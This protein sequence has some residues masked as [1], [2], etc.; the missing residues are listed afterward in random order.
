LRA[1]PAGGLPFEGGT[2]AVDTSLD[3][4]SPSQGSAKK[5]GKKKKGAK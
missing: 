3:G 4:A 2:G 1:G 5:K